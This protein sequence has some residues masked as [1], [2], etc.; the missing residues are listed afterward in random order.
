MPTFVPSSEGGL[1]PS[2][3]QVVTSVPANTKSTRV[4][5]RVWAWGMG[6]VY[7]STLRRA[8]PPHQLQD[9]RAWLLLAVSD[10]DAAA[11]E[12]PTLC[13]GAKE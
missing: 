1:C 13:F 5:R 7:S 6:Q 4:P 10:G 2:S 11:S 3:Y 9:R 8:P 12:S